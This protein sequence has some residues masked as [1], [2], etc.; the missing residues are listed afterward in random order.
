MPVEI[1]V[2]VSNDV[3]EYT[4]EECRLLSRF[5]RMLMIKNMVLLSEQ[6]ALVDRA[7]VKAVDNCIDAR[8]SFEIAEIQRQFNDKIKTN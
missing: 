7:F 3:K 8:L 5:A 6:Q 1:Q 4:Q 2:S